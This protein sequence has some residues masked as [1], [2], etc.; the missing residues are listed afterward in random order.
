MCPCS[1]LLSC[2]GAD[3]LAFNGVFARSSPFLWWWAVNLSVGIGVQPSFP[4]LALLLAD[5]SLRT[6]GCSLDAYVFDFSRFAERVVREPIKV[7]NVAVK[8]LHGTG[9][10]V[11]NAGEVN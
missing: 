4:T 7:G 2:S 5:C 11:P 1:V 9:R 8:V 3:L 10:E 6:L